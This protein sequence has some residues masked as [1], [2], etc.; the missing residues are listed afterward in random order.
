MSR[1]PSPSMC[2][3]RPAGCCWKTPW[4]SHQMYPTPCK[5]DAAAFRRIRSEWKSLLWRFANGYFSPW[6]VRGTDCVWSAQSSRGRR[7]CDELLGIDSQNDGKQSERK[8]TVESRRSHLR[9]LSPSVVPRLQCLRLPTDVHPCVLRNLSS[10]L[11]ARTVTG[12]RCCSNFSFTTSALNTG[13]S[14]S[15]LHPSSVTSPPGHAPFLPTFR[16]VPP[17][18]TWLRRIRWRQRRSNTALCWWWCWSC[19]SRDC[20]REFNQSMRYNQTVAMTAIV[21]SWYS[22]V[23]WDQLAVLHGAAWDVSTC[24]LVHCLSTHHWHY[25]MSLPNRRTPREEASIPTR[26]V[27]NWEQHHNPPSSSCHPCESHSP[28]LRGQFKLRWGASP[29]NAHHKR[30]DGMDHVLRGSFQ[31]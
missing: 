10:C 25:H 12:R 23:M 3:S 22:V 15:H 13:I 14:F 4:I 6:D 20:E 28:R 1:H 5:T 18:P 17:P 30:G 26:S 24:V 2:V 7:P 19:A 8:Q 29:H 27:F 9:T 11:L 16:A 21:G 31:W